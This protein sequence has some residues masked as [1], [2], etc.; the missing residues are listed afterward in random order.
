MNQGNLNQAILNNGNMNQGYNP[1]YNNA[2]NNGG[3]QIPPPAINAGYNQPAPNNFINNNPQFNGGYGTGGIN[4]NQINYQVNPVNT[5]G[6]QMQGF[7]NGGAQVQGFNNGGTQNI[8]QPQ[9]L[10]KGS[11]SVSVNNKPPSKIYSKLKEIKKIAQLQ[12]ILLISFGR[13]F[14]I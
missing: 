10:V 3:Y 7:N 12:L 11:S 2:G 8:S 14:K 4:P 6:A 1:Q 5:G 13:I 9:R